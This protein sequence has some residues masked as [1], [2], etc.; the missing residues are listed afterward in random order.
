[1][2]AALRVTSLGRLVA[3]IKSCGITSCRIKSCGRLAN[4]PTVAT[5]DWRCVAASETATVYL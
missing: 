1:M 5:G 2:A 4:H 3:E